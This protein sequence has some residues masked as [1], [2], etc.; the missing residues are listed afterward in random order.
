MHL[1]IIDS[2]IREHETQR[3]TSRSSALM[4]R[5]LTDSFSQKVFDKFR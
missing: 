3:G 2:F 4:I 5:P 1:E